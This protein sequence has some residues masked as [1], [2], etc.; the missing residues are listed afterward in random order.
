MPT[1]KPPIPTKALQPT[2]APTPVAP[3]E[4]LRPGTSLDDIFAKASALTCV[5]V[6]VFKSLIAQESPGVLTYSQKSAL[7]YNAYDWWHRVT[8]KQ[9]VCSGYGYYPE[10]GLIAEDSMFAGE[11]CKAGINGDTISKAMGASQM[12]KYYWDKVYAEKT[13]Q[14]L[15]VDKVD[16]RVLLDA[17]VGWGIDIKEGTKYSGSCTNWDFKH[18]MQ[19]ACINTGAT[20]NCKTYC[21]T[22]CRNFNRFTGQ[23]NDCSNVV[24]IFVPGSYCQFK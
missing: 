15:K 14:V 22:I 3:A 12:L 16:R 9:Q 7:F 19:A 18:A 24:A 21:N 23:N 4:Y 17:L 8:E 5:S 13:K 2:A 10:T 1:E 11:S 6:D 20:D